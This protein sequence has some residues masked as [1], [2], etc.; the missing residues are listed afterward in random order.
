LL[1]LVVCEGV[2]FM[3]LR[4]EHEMVEQ[5]AAVELN[6]EAL[7]KVVGGCSE[8]RGGDWRHHHDNHDWN[9]HH[10]HDHD[11]GWGWSHHHR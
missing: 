4:K 9:W 2:D 11:H 1:N 10:S 8:H 3:D 5:S 7:E 6:D